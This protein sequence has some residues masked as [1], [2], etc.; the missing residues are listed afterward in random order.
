MTKKANQQ[1][2]NIAEYLIFRFLSFIA[3]SLE[4]HDNQM[5]IIL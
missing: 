4:F 1:R 3:L 5:V 2:K